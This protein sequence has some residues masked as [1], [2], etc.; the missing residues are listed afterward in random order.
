[1]WGVKSISGQKGSPLLVPMCRGVE[2]P[3]FRSLCVELK[4]PAYLSWLVSD[5]FHSQHK[6]AA[7]GI[8]F[9]SI[10]FKSVL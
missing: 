5:T 6:K 7:V 4:V 9:L 8:M 1:M 10:A 3:V 2:G